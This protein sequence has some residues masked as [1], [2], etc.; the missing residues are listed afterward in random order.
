MLTKIIVIVIVLQLVF[1]AIGY[2]PGEEVSTTFQVI[3]A[4]LKTQ[5]SDLAVGKMPK[6]R[7]PEELMLEFKLPLNEK[8]KG[9]EYV[10]QVDKNVALSLAFDSRKLILPRIKLYDAEK[11]KSL[12]ELIVTFTHDEFEIVKV[13]HEMICK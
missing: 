3:H 4:G 1:V 5:W 10:V 8:V 11:R 7:I 9:S 12:R 13:Q 2:Q 6:Y